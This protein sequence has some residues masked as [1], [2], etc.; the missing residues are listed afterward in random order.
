[1]ELKIANPDSF[2]AH[3]ALGISEER[4][5]QLCD[6]MTAHVK[7]YSIMSLHASLQYVASICKT[8]EE[9]A[10]LSFTHGCYLTK[11]NAAQFPNMH[12]RQ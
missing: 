7:Q 12:N 2:M 5:N 9:L 11:N 8:V 10:W 1:M 6:L 4:S 3:T